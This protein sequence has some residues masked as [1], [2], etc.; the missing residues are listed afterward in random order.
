MGNLVF[1]LIKH[2]AEMTS[3]MCILCFSLDAIP[4]AV[5][6]FYS[7]VNPVI[8]KLNKKLLHD[9][10]FFTISGHKK[11]RK[12]SGLGSPACTLRAHISE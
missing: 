4:C 6:I 8:V 11:K 7:T 12:K 9:N 3:L 1:Q 5:L 10:Y 2:A